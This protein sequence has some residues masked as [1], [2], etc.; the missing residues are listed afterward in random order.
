MR[1]KKTVG[2]YFKEFSG[3]YLDNFEACVNVICDP[4]KYSNSRNLKLY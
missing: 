3:I 1:Y 2:E 4:S